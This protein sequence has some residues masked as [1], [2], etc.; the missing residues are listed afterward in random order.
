MKLRNLKV[1]DAPLMLE[2]MHDESVVGKLRTDFSKKTLEDCKNF[3]EE[4]NE[5]YNKKHKSFIHFAIEDEEGE[6]QGTVSLKNIESSQAEFAITIRKKAMGTGCSIWVM[7]SIMEY[8][9]NELGLDFVYWCVSPENKRA[10]RFYDKNHFQRIEDEDFIYGT[11]IKAG[12]TP[13]QIASY[14]WYVDKKQE[15]L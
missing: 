3:I 2:W 11:A 5:E 9:Y 4:A 13:E 8:A 15:K 7:K 6:Y 1:G 10:V 14:I 12:Y